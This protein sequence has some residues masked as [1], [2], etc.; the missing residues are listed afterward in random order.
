[1]QQ[2]DFTVV[3]LYRKQICLMVHCTRTNKSKRYIGYDYFFE[4]ILMIIILDI[5]IQNSL[6][7]P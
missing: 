7:K 6:K 4:N 3:K 2:R 5:Q 1:M